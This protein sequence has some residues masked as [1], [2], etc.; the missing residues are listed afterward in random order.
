MLSISGEDINKNMS[1]KLN[2][3]YTKLGNKQKAIEYGKKAAINLERILH[4]NK[5]TPI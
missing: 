3:C 2:M 1:L 5:K 4:I